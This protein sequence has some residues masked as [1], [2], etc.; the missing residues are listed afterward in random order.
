MPA[1]E[2]AAWLASWHPDP[3]WAAVQTVSRLNLPLLRAMVEYRAWT[4]AVEAFLLGERSEPPPIDPQQC[5]FGIWLHGD[6]PL[7]YGTQTAFKALQP[8]CQQGYELA[9]AL[10]DLKA[11]QG[12]VAALARMGELHDCRDAMLHR[13]QSLARGSP[14]A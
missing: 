12:V 14:S 4:A 5:R 3:A 13:L 6:G 1:A 8:L 11:S 10:I 9:T 2:L 7:H